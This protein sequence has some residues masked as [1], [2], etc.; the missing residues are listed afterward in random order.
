MELNKSELEQVGPGRLYEI[1]GATDDSLP[2]QA[3]LL[4]ASRRETCI[5]LQ[6]SQELRTVSDFVADSNAFAGINGGF[7]VM[8]TG[9]PLDWMVVDGKV[10]TEAVVPQ[11]ACIFIE[12]GHASIGLP[13]ERCNDADVMQAGPMLLREGVILTDYTDYVANARQ[14]DCDI[15]AHRFP[16][17]IFGTSETDY[18]FLVV[19]GRSK[20]SAGLFLN[21]CAELALKLGMKHAVNLDGGGSS[22]LVAGSRL[23]NNP[24]ASVEQIHPEERA[25][26]T[27]LLAFSLPR[28]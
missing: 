25:V 9:L 20:V 17:T 11:R 4:A 28:Q 21:E 10:I 26:P 14:F 6:H 27:A 23:L 18:H 12:N 5:K 3:F 2:F 13:H 1:N 22:A 15:T 24:R 8:S 16:R 7:Y 19:D